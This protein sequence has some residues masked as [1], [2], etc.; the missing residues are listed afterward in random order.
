MRFSAY[1]PWVYLPGGPERVLT[2]ILARS[3]HEWTILTNHFDSKA[4]FPQLRE[5]RVIELSPVSVKRN[6]STV[7]KAGIRILSQQLPLDGQDALLVLCEGL[8][9][10]VLRKTGGVPA[11]CLCL[12]PLRIAFDDA[13]REHYLANASGR[14][15]R[16]PLLEAMLAV[17]R[18]LDR[19][20]WRKYRR[21]FAI[22]ETV[23]DRIAAG[24]LYRRESV[25]VLYPGVD[26]EK[27]R[28]SGLRTKNFLVPGRIMWT[29][30]IE[31]AV[32]AFQR[33]AKRRPD[34]GEFT[35]TIA[36]HVDRKSEP[37]WEKLHA[38]AAGDLRI[39]F[40][41][42]LSDAD[43]FSLLS[44]SYAVL[45]T[46]FNEDWGLVPIEA[47]ALE[48]PVIAVNR[49]GPR[50]TVVDGST[51]YLVEPGADAFAAA[52]ERL[53]DSPER[54]EL[55]GKQARARAARFD[56]NEFVRQLDDR[57]E[58]MVTGRPATALAEEARI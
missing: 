22:S 7:A 45:F 25:E 47:M 41:R 8:G 6:F 39:R 3:R 46:A 43:L 48:R 58:E 27:L 18:P 42:G 24:R 12:T 9:D 32:E 49:G 1:Y 53:A 34:L 40:R 38:M 26:L 31:L 16:Q 23:R 52:M 57:L 35:L 10:F 33:F 55:M 21:V 19:M 13:Y 54:T 20:L 14:R 29:K 17:F 4:T 56:A 37:Y 15:W 30:N 36:G 11:A 51:G 2:D 44:E 28:P 50:E 5:A